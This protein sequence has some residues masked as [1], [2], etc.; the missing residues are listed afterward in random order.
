[1]TTKEALEKETTINGKNG[2]VAII[3]AVIGAMISL[4]ILQSPEDKINLQL[5][6]QSM[7]Y[8]IDNIDTRL[9]AFEKRLDSTSGNNWS[10]NDAKTQWVLVKEL[11]PDLVIPIPER[12]Y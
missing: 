10:Y 12:A 3:A 11:N 4:G 5:Q 6:L 2:L 8:G 1:M 7:S 9:E